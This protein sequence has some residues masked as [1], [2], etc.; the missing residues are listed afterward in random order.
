MYKRSSRARYYYVFDIDELERRKQNCDPLFTGGRERGADTDDP[1]KTT[2]REKAKIEIK[3][4]RKQ[5]GK[6]KGK[7]KRKIEL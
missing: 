5:Q 3:K 1:S 4:E 2:T 6:E 7:E